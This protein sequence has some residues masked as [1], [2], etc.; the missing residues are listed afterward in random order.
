M[1]K[2]GKSKPDAAPPEPDVNEQIHLILREAAEKREARLRAQ[3][4]ADEADAS[5]QLDAV[6]TLARAQGRVQR[7]WSKAPDIPDRPEPSES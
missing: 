3:S 4:I 5:R 1:S 2:A 7:R 6:I